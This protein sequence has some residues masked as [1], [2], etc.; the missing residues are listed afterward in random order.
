M[1]ERI[2]LQDLKNL[3]NL[4]S[5]EAKKRVV[6]EFVAKNPHVTKLDLNRLFSFFCLLY[7]RCS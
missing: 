1:K 4:S 6:E 7:V 5:F 3:K 2:S